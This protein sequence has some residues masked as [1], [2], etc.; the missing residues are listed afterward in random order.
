MAFG[1]V[2]GD[3]AT[4]RGVVL[5]NPFSEQAVMELADPASGG[6]VARALSFP[7]VVSGNDSRIVDVT[8]TPGGEAAAAGSML[9]RFVAGERSAS[10]RVEFRATVESPTL[11]LFTPQVALG[12]AFIG[13]SSSGTITFRNTSVVTP[14]RLYSLTPLPAGLTLTGGLGDIAPGTATNITVRWSPTAIATHDVDVVFEHDASGPSRIVR[15][16]AQAT[17]WPLEQIAEFGSVSLTDGETEWLEVDV[18]PH[19]ISLSIEAVADD[20]RIGLLE[21]EGPGD[22]VYENDTATGEFLWFPGED[23]FTATLPSSDRTELMLVPGGGTYRFRLYRMSGSAGSFQVRAIV[24]NRPLGVVSGGRVDLNVFL[25]AGLGFDEFD[26]PTETKLQDMLDELG[27][28]FSQQGLQL[29]DVNYLALSNSAFDEVTSNAEFGD[30]LEESSRGV[31]GRLNLFLV[32]KTLS[33]SVV[34]VAA[35]IAGP[36]SLGT[37][38]SGVMVDYDSA[39]ASRVGYIA[40]HEIGHFLGLIHTT[41]QD[42]GHDLVDDTLECPATGTDATCSTEGNANLMHWRVLTADPIITDGQGRV[43]LG[44]PLVD[45]PSSSRMRSRT[46]LQSGPVESPLLAA[47]LPDGWCGTKGC[48]ASGK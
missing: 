5:V 48:C 33:G 29:G 37:R 41:E 40:A 27:R 14:V 12:D 3:V 20:T 47:A 32:K 30:M 18:P 6:F 46:S 38:A 25:A 13:E 16:T 42:G 4:T 7:D 15:V 1:V 19:G 24:H 45:P 21:F 10:V 17:T 28:I 9:V 2:R 39:G 43:I 31:A 35:R 11:S 34:G 44:H 8:F 26:A 23:V 36:S 22:R